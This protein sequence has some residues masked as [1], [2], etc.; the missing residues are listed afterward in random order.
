MKP[1]KILQFIE[2][3]IILLVLSILTSLTY[4]FRG[5]IFV[6]LVRL[7]S[8]AI[9]KLSYRSLD[10]I[11]KAFPEVSEE[12]VQEI[13]SHSMDNLGYFLN[14]FLELKNLEKMM[15]NDILVHHPDE[16]GVIDYFKDGAIVVLGH[17]GNWECHGALVS[18]WMPGK[19]CAVARPQSNPWTNEMIVKIRS[20]NGVKT[21][22]ADQ[23]F[24]EM[25]KILK[26]KGVL[27]LLADQDARHHGKIYNFLGRP[28]STFMGPALFA[29]KTG[30][31]TYFGYSIRKE[32]KIHLFVDKIRIEPFRDNENPREWDNRFTQTWVSMLEDAVRKYPEEYFWLH[33]RWK[34]GQRKE[35]ESI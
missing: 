24:F 17:M 6:K 22:F 14:E 31:K 1:K 35:L 5:K 15:S 32:G 20:K 12:R 3:L 28:A 13:S 7:I 19:I 25:K 30:T 26:E 18:H 21:I 8:K 34:S 29:R 10:N 4:S 27:C 2:Y 11:R 9:P 16:K 23:G 33:N